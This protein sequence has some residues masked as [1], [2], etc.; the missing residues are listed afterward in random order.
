MNIAYKKTLIDCSCNECGHK[1]KKDKDYRVAVITNKKDL[2]LCKTCYNE[3]V[4]K[5]CI[6]NIE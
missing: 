5:I 4:I 6:T 3:L 1:F 2:I